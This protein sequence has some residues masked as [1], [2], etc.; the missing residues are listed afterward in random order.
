MNKFPMKLQI[1]HTFTNQ[2]LLLLL[3]LLLLLL[4]LLLPTMLRVRQWPL[5]HW[6]LVWPQL[7]RRIKGWPLGVLSCLEH[8]ILQLLHL[9]LLLPLLHQLLPLLLLMLLS[10]LLL[11]SLCNGC[12]CAAASCSVGY[13]TCN[14]EALSC[15]GTRILLGRPV[16]ACAAATAAADAMLAATCGTWGPQGCCA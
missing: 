2:V 1:S 3:M 7:L 16:S 9:L 12:G 14:S 5:W 8:C 15:F 11:S 6:Q 10:L 13:N 4:L